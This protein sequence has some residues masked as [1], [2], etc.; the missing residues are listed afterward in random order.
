LRG[1]GEYKAWN[2]KKNRTIISSLGVDFRSRE[3][4]E[5]RHSVWFIRFHNFEWI[6]QFDL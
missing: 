2:L 1:L 5:F 6:K 3:K 4:I